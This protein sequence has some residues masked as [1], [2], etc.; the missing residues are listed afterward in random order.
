MFVLPDLVVEASSCERTAEKTDSES[1]ATLGLAFQNAERLLT[2]E[3]AYPSRSVFL[4]EVRV[5]DADRNDGGSWTDT[6]YSNSRDRQGYRPGKVIQGESAV[7]FSAADIAERDF[8]RHHCFWYGG[9]DRD[10]ASGI[11]VIR[12]NFVPTARTKSPDWAGSLV[13]DSASSVLLRSEALLVNIPKRSSF[14]SARCIVDYMEI[15]PTLVHESR[16]VCGI[17][18]R[19]LQQGFVLVERWTLR[20]HEFLGPRP[21]SIAGVAPP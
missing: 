7:Y 5:L 15:V 10:S 2:L 19:K 1:E 18:T 16:A 13:L 6:L 14:T 12:I 17:R 4:K 21:D 9:R 11:P 8:R 3:R 20:R